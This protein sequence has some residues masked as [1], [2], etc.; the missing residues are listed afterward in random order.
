[1][2]KMEPE[3]KQCQN[4]KKDFTIESEDFNFYEK[5]KVPPP[6]WC[7]ECRLTRRMMWRNE[8]ALFR[9]PN[10]ENGKNDSHISIYHPDAKITTYDRETWWGDTWD[11]RDYGTDYDFTRPFFEQFQE[12]LGRVPQVALFDSK[13]VNS[14]FCNQT[15]EM[16]N[17]YLVSATWSSEDSMYC[18]RLWHCKYT[19][20]SYICF[21]IEFGYENVYC[22]DSSKL[23]FSRES[24]NCL[25][26]YFLYD[27]RNCSNC[28]LSTNLR[29]KS[30][31]IENVQYTREEYFKKK[32]ELALNTRA[33]IEQ[34]KGKFEKMWRGAF[35]KHLKLTNTDN[36]VGDQVSNSRNS[37]GVFDFNN[38]AD[39]VKYVNWGAKS[40]KDSYDV[41]PGCGDGSELTYEGVGVG[42]QDNKVLFCSIAWYCSDVLYSYAMNNSRDCFGCT[43]MNGKQYC[44]LN[45]Q[46]S[47]E[48][49][50]AL[51]P[52]IIQHM[53]DMPYVD[54]S[55]LK[56]E[57]GEF[58]PAEISPFAYNESIAQDYFPITPNIAEQ[59]GY[60]WREYVPNTYVTS[61][62]G[63]DLPDKIED[64]E[65][66]IL[67][68]VIECEVT[69]K[70]FKIFEDE[71]SFYKRLNLPVPSVHPDERHN[72]RLRLRNEMR[73]Y[74]RKC[75][76]CEKI[77]DTTYRPVEAGGPE[78]VY[79]ESCYN[80]EVY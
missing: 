63:Q 11:P 16:K 68:E 52:K 2:E 49:Y 23:V 67:D 3:T 12:L 15:V 65:K 73:F 78:K 1:M 43:A 33:G 17:S 79:C 69:K 26:S 57:F 22:R 45:K 18:N 9:R 32:E 46:Y 64:V 31:C 30:Y 25:D 40:L 7:P 34:A 4:C 70:P 50:E 55:G 80:K 74:K 21:G 35:H 10:G 58:F 19:H 60:R 62:R 54:K 5:I 71:L 51:V 13:S 24:E 37:Y 39:N 29:N 6:T 76:N 44:I 27:C 28:I 77:V 36:V 61:I 14:R 72:R 56:Y 20:D 59:S 75:Y 47:K 66:S 48:E 41:G 38:G 42:V 53:K 8:K